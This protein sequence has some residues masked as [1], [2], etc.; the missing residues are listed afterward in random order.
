M[1]ENCKNHRSHCCESKVYW[2]RCR[3]CLLDWFEELLVE[4]AVGPYNISEIGSYL[5]GLSDY[6]HR[7]SIGDF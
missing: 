2:V 6:S 7:M 4:N 5:E 3:S 1:S